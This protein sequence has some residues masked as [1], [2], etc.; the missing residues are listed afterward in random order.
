MANRVL[1]ITGRSAPNEFRIYL[2]PT[3]DPVNITEQVMSTTQRYDRC[4]INPYD[5]DQ[6]LVAYAAG[7]RYST[8]GGL[9]FGNSPV[10]WNGETR[11]LV[12]IASSKFIAAK[13]GKLYKSIDAGATW[14]DITPVLPGTTIT[15][16]YMKGI[17]GY[18]LSSFSVGNT[19]GYLSR[20]SDEGANWSDVLDLTSMPGWVALESPRRV[21]AS[22]D[23]DIVYVLSSHRLWKIV[24]M[25]GVPTFS[26][27]WTFAGTAITTSLPA[28]DVASSGYN[29]LGADTYA[30][31]DDL[32]VDLTTGRIWLAGFNELRAHSFDQVSF[33]LS[34]VGAAINLAS[35]GYKTHHVLLDGN[36]GFAGAERDA[37][38]VPS[39][40]IKPGIWTSSNGM[41]TTT[42]FKQFPV[43]EELL[44]FS[45]VGDV[46]SGG[47]TIPTACNFNSDATFDDGSCQLAVVLTDCNTGEQFHTSSQNITSLGCRNPRVA[48]N[49]QQLAADSTAQ[50]FVFLMDGVVQFTYNAAVSPI[51]L[52]VQERVT[53]FLQGLIAY[54]NSST[55]FTAIQIPP[56]QNTLQPGSENGIWIICD[57]NSCANLSVNILSLNLNGVSFESSFDAGS[58]GSVV[59]VAE[60]PGRCLRVC[61][62]GNCALAQD[63]T[64]TADYASCYVC[65]PSS[66]QGGACIDCSGMVSYGA[67][68]LIATD[69]NRHI[70]CIAAGGQLNFNLNAVFPDRTSTTVVPLDVLTVPPS[71][72]PLV[73]QFTGNVMDQF[74]PGSS[75]T[76]TPGGTTYTVGSVSYDI[77]TDV[78]TVISVENSDETEAIASVDT[79]VSCGCQVDVFVDNLT[80]GINH[81]TT[82]FPCVDGQVNQQFFWIVPDHGEYRI[83]IIARDCGLEKRCVYYADACSEFLIRQYA[84]HQYDVILNRPPNT[85]ASA[86]PHTLTITDLSDGSIVYQNNTLSDADFPI[87]LVNDH[88][89]VYRI[90]LQLQDGR[91]YE[92]D[93]IDTCDME[94]C[95]KKIATEIFCG[96]EDPCQEKI[97]PAITVRRMEVARISILSNQLR[98]AVMSYRQRW[99]GLPSYS[100]E[101]I[102]D[103]D[104]IAKILKTIHSTSVQCGVC[105][106]QEP[107]CSNCLPA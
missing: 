23:M 85:G 99:F 76:T 58:L 9:S 71:G 97:D 106:K 12:A 47:C 36:T 6:M 40:P 15:D 24:G 26:I 98:D 101:R 19:G 94:N 78:T 92:E 90:V 69:T 79:F 44:H 48:V 66:V 33:F 74:P 83:T 8:D 80:T 45:A 65:N 73:L 18:I 17:N 56:A 55:T 1:A 62:V 34:D 14:S 11:S 5:H 75:F 100:A 3:T 22:D 27:L 50:Q 102:K 49:I 68:P 37:S 59:E 95:L 53:E 30:L 96:E 57:T 39:P 103:L 43:K 89:T 63:Y 86:G 64:L 60:L 25:N 107:P 28:I 38:V 41:V 10:V 82:S 87:R 51:G 81:L 93:I 105:E 29:G 52:T 84:C 54:I 16:I 42:F 32:H 70:Q 46:S 21:F 61:G 72:Q 91:V 67:T 4:L 35:S 104:L 77:G 13:P 2:G 7:L 31:F 88:D 20:T